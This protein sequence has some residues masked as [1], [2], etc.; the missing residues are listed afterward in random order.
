MC[1]VVACAM[2]RAIVIIIVIASLI[3]TAVGAMLVG[4]ILLLA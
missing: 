2:I 4:A 1:V 3:E